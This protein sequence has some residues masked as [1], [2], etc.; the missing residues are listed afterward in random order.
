MLFLINKDSDLFIIPANYRQEASYMQ[1][2]C[3]TYINLP[4]EKVIHLFD[5]PEN[6]DKWMEGLQS[7]DH[8]SGRQGYPGA[9]SR[10]VFNNE[11]RRLELIETILSRNLPEE[12][13]GFY[14]TKGIINKV[15]NYFYEEGPERTRWVAENEFQFSGL[16]NLMSIF[17]RSAF[18]KQTQRHM[19]NFKNFAENS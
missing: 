15:A 17:I 7:V 9:K 4:R 16:M 13:S 11:G 1:F 6:L 2:S 12:F 5:N 10:M 8:I 19:E 3:E 14:E 18:P